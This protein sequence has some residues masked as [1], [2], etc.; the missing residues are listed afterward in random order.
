MKKGLILVCALMVGLAFVAYALPVRQMPKNIRESDDIK[1]DY[2]A[3]T[4]TK[5]A[6]LPGV[7]IGP[8][9]Y[10]DAWRGTASSQGKSL[11]ITPDGSAMAT[12]YGRKSA[13]GTTADIIFNYSYNG[14]TWVPMVL[15]TKMN[16]RIYNGLALDYTWVPYVIWQDRDLNSM[17]W[18]KDEGSFGAG[19]WTT[20]DTL[21]RDSA[22]Y[23]LPSIDVGGDRMAVS[24]FA[25]DA[26]AP[27]G[28][29]TIHMAF[30]EDLGTSWMAPWIVNPL[31]YGWNRWSYDNTYPVVGIDNADW[32]FSPSSDTVIGFY[33][34]VVDEA[35]YN[36]SAGFS[37]FG[38]AYK[39]SYDGGVTWSAPVLLPLPKQYLDGGW[40][41]R[42]EGI[43]VG[44][45]PFLMYG[46]FN[47]Q[48]NGG[49]ILVY[50]P[51]VAGD[52]SNWDCQRISDISVSN[53]SG[54]GVNTYNGGYADYPALASDEAGNIFAVY[55]D[56]SKTAIRSE[57]F[58]VASTD[59]GATWLSPV[60]LTNMLG[61]L[62]GP[63]VYL[64]AANTVTSDNK[65]H[66]VYQD[67]LY[68][69]I[70]YA[71]FS[72]A[73]IL[74][75]PARPNDMTL[76]PVLCGVVDDSAFAGGPAGDGTV[77]VITGPLL[78]YW[79][80]IVGVDGQYE[81]LAS[82]TSD[83]SANVYQ[84]GSSYSDYNYACYTYGP[85][86]TADVEI[87]GMPSNGVWYWK[88]RSHKGAEV[89]PWSTV[90]DF[91][92]QGTA[93]DNTI[94]KVTGITGGDR[95]ASSAFMLNQSFPNP[96]RDNAAISFSLPRAGAYSLKVYNVAGQVVRTMNGT[97]TA[98]MNTVN[99]NSRNLSNG[100][101]FYQLT[102]NNNTAT[103]KMVVLK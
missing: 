41:Y 10:G 52:Y 46:V 103:K 62:D 84:F 16:V 39:I 66:A 15:A 30:S 47:S 37:G 83:F 85:Y 95:V 55:M 81:L 69:N 7:I 11:I 6:T 34:I 63:M 70:Y 35:G 42:F 86:G 59:G 87:L 92:Y 56:C 27:A 74:A 20:K 24:A 54:V 94:W 102:A 18:M 23:Y 22:A 77:N 96:V 72:T 21:C 65:I 53:Q 45:K 71:N 25:N 61:D 64:E 89:S 38:A 40:W 76:A 1:V 12:V 79:S 75:A 49:A 51:T 99:V 78:F 88:V 50:T 58:G 14:I 100:V 26:V 9:G 2:S 82:T 93:L 60:A 90:F 91:D 32:I 28:D 44:D 4:A 3:A 17:Q 67:S 68:T 36:L 97:G 19:S 13:T 8:T 48:W 5:A 80:P 33:D 98:G 43:W 31:D 57:V 73:P 29:N 101:Y